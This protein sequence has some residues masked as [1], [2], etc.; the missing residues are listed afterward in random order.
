MAIHSSILAWRIPWTEETSRLQSMGLHSVRHDWSDSARV[1]T[2]GRITF[3]LCICG[4]SLLASHTPPPCTCSPVRWPK[5]LS[6]P[7]SDTKAQAT[8]WKIMIRLQLSVC[9][10]RKEVDLQRCYHQGIK[11]SDFHWVPM[12]LKSALQAWSCPAGAGILESMRHGASGRAGN[13]WKACGRE[14]VLASW[15]FKTEEMQRANEP[16]KDCSTTLVIRKMQIKTTVTS[17]SPHPEWLKLQRLATPQCWIWRHL[18]AHTLL[19]TWGKG[20]MEE[21]AVVDLWAARKE[22]AQKKS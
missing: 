6:D 13:N 19:G 22:S 7:R 11:V 10:T 9:S 18:N 14:S 21:D 2:L 12:E 20:W 17:H 3:V 15:P 1:H 16:M 4:F 8:W 5:P